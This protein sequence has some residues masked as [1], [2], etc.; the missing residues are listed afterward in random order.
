MNF[1][2]KGTIMIFTIYF[3]NIFR[4][5]I[6]CFFCTSLFHVSNVYASQ[7]S[8]EEE[9]LPIRSSPLNR[10]EDLQEGYTI[11]GQEFR[12]QN[13][14][15]QGMRCFFN[16]IGLEA[17]I[18][19]AKLRSKQDDLLIRAM[20]ANEI[21][22]AAANPNQLPTQV[23][24]AI[25]Y[26]LY[27]A[28]RQELSHL[29]EL[30]SDKL[31]AQSSD[32]NKQDTTVLPQSLRDLRQKDQDILEDLRKRALTPESFKAFLD[33]HIGNEQMMVALRD[34]KGEEGD[35]ENGNLTSIDAISYINKIALRIYQPTSERKLRLAHQYVPIGA[36]EVAHLY[37]QGVHFQAL[38]LSADSTH[39]IQEEE[40]MK[41]AL[42]CLEHQSGILDKPTSKNEE[43][44]SNLKKR[45]R[46]DD[47]TSTMTSSSNSLPSS[48]RQKKSKE[49]ETFDKE[50]G[51]YIFNVGQG[52]SQLA[53]YGERGDPF[54]VLYDCGSSTEAVNDKILKTRFFEEGKYQTFIQPSSLEMSFSIKPSDQ[55]EETLAS[56]MK[57]TV[58]YIPESPSSSGSSGSISYEA[59]KR[60][61]NDKDDPLDKTDLPSI[62]KIIETYQLKHLFVFLSH[63]DQDHINLLKDNI[64]ETLKVFL[65]LC[66]DFL[67]LSDT[68]GLILED[69]HDVFTFIFERIRYDP[70]NTKFSLPYF[71]KHPKYSE[72]K[73]AIKKYSFCM[74]SL[75]KDELYQN[76]N[77]EDAKGK[78]KK[79]I[80]IEMSLVQNIEEDVAIVDSLG[81]ME[82][83]IRVPILDIL[84]KSVQSV[85]EKSRTNA[86]QP[87]TEAYI[88]SIMQEKG[89][90]E[91]ANYIRNLNNLY[92]II[93]LQAGYVPP[94]IQGSLKTFLDKA[95]KFDIPQSI[96]REH[97]TQSDNYSFFEEHEDSQYLENIYIW[98]LN[99]VSTN[100]NNTCPIIS[101]RM[102]T[103]K[104]S[105]ICTGDAE[106]DIF[107]DIVQTIEER[108]GDNLGSYVQSILSDVGVHEPY[109]I[110]LMLPHHGAKDNKS[111]P[112]LDLFQP[113]V[114]GIS[115]G[116]GTKYAHPD[117][118]LITEY[119]EY[120][121]Q[122]ETLKAR[123]ST[124]WSTFEKVTNYYYLTFRETNSPYLYKLKRSRLP[125]LCPNMLGSIRIQENFDTQ[126]SHGYVWNGAV[127]N[128]KFAKKIENYSSRENGR[129][130][131]YDGKE[132]IYQPDENDVGSCSYL[133]Q[134]N[135]SILLEL[136]ILGSN[137]TLAPHNY[138]LGL[139]EEPNDVDREKGL[140]DD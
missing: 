126:F 87:I 49:Q 30:R 127:F 10:F 72:I 98:F 114:L 17:D 7:N 94:R 35:N 18:E 122:N 58:E 69:V 103:L 56:S 50:E 2:I 89:I 83:N 12:R 44:F 130:I 88:R 140:S 92:E 38:V 55:I 133:S 129:V 29:Q 93:S 48:P 19:I 42:D 91:I 47:T 1:C 9:S 36:T 31:R 54:G 110:L 53:I 57:N 28:Q 65:I 75:F 61:K 16:A 125:V 132:Y 116:A 137:D 4:L 80:E 84:K 27:E 43:T 104:K 34:V 74:E 23:K 59:K 60:G 33:H 5:V 100:P 13:V 107:A 118:A 24:D 32:G 79:Q 121:R 62:K 135:D 22:S 40:N 119:E 81:G 99:K 85:I 21:V 117:T 105:F 68:T 131:E 102:P 106:P 108:H 46:A 109:T 66:G 95:N 3:K 124:F 8:N 78:L 41:L 123:L 138:Y 63:P 64:P 113:H 37:H 115:A 77:L 76:L 82:E 136:D 25:G 101:F 90:E 134:E 45:M 71:W 52:N 11:N 15:G 6:S 14:S 112:M 97:V 111:F 128:I 73:E 51:F 26:S 120:Y 139:K 86:A 96:E 39:E 70:K 20:I 67:R